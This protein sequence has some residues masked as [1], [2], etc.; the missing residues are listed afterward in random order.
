[1]AV[2][3]PESALE[4]AQT[5]GEKALLR[6]LRDSLDD[7]CIVWYNPKVEG[8]Q[9]PDVL[10]YV[11]T[12]GLTILEVKDWSTDAIVDA[13]PDSWRVIEQGK[14]KS[15]TCPLKQAKEYFYRLSTSFQ[16]T[17]TLISDAPPHEGK[18]RVPVATAVAFP[19]ISLED[20]TNK[21]LDL[22]LDPKHVW[23]RENIAELKQ[24][25]SAAVATRLLR[26]L[27]VVWWPTEALEE[28]DLDKLRGVLY[29]EL[30]SIQRDIGGATREIILDTYQENVTQTIKEGHT[31]VLGVA[32][33][34]KSLVL[35]ALARRLLREHP[36]WNILV[37]CYNVSLASQLKYYV[38]SF[39]APDSDETAAIKA[40]AEARLTIDNFHSLA[41]GIF[42]SQKQPY[43][44][45]NKDQVMQT[46]TL[47]SK[48]DHEVAKELDEMESALLGTSLQN[49]LQMRRVQLFDA[50][51][52]DES[53][54]FHPSW[55]RALTLLLN[56]K[57]NWLVMA[58]DPNQKIY[59]R[60]FSYRD[61]G[62]NV[63][64]RKAFKL[65]ISYRST[66][67]I[68]LTASKVLL[69]DGKAW[70]K[71]Y[72]DYVAEEPLEFNEKTS[73]TTGRPPDIVVSRNYEDS[74]EDVVRDIVE[75][76]RDGF[77]FGDIG[78]IYLTK[79]LRSALPK[80]QLELFKDEDDI[81]Y[82]RTLLARLGAA[83]I[84][85][86]WLTESRETKASYD[87]FRNAVTVTTIFGAKG[88]EFGAAYVMGLELFPWS[89]RNER[90][91]NSL[92]YVAMT[93]A[94][95]VLRLYSTRD[96]PTTERIRAVIKSVSGQ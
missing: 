54:D 65:P 47:Q 80:Q 63:V 51:L 44:F 53:Q 1:M 34:G 76:V 42:R 55:L 64:G 14:T 75:K 15:K 74:C 19:N 13:N 67:E 9:R 48:R 27:F 32:G 46:A 73:R 49:L 17:N 79:T 41:A 6:V 39:G 45:L 2:L 59:P 40:A 72:A 22:V 5:P 93:R 56:G 24:S 88:L 43:P 96:T 16:R 92:L 78:V 33:S 52:V 81:D 60:S 71:F 57:T 95:H 83:G 62:V 35:M 12:L 84:P 11:P 20:Y 68:V 89:Q 70:D 77:E 85:Y 4:N 66:R 90:E 38:R 8:S 7:A 18:L 37:T 61:A 86:Y 58:E 30:T 36:D 69:E 25:A 87:Q 3:I 10:V 50:I 91:N 82:V 31:R 23:F 26:G 29:P 28:E 94:K 21:R